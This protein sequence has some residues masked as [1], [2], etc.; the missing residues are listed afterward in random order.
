MIRDLTSIMPEPLPARGQELFDAW[1]IHGGELDAGDPQ[2][3]QTASETLLAAI[4]KMRGSMV[5]FV[6]ELR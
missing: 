1:Q 2:T 3:R 6:D 5:K 4:E